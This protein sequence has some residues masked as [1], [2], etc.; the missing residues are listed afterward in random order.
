MASCSSQASHWSK[1]EQQRVWNSLQKK[2][3]NQN[4]S[5]TQQLAT[6]QSAKS[7]IKRNGLNA[8][9]SLNVPGFARG[10]DTLAA[11]LPRSRKACYTSSEHR[12]VE[13]LDTRIRKFRKG[14]IEFTR[15]GHRALR[16][17]HRKDETS[18][19]RWILSALLH[20]HLFFFLLAVLE[21]IL[22]YVQTLR[23][24]GNRRHHMQG[25]TIV[26]FR[27]QHM[28]HFHLG[29]TARTRFAVVVV[30]LSLVYPLV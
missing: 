30:C 10:S 14:Q 8:K 15:K 9:P 16:N 29:S 22:L 5:A 12:D 4:P 21:L 3:K 17:F 19:R 6:L 2:E 23:G 1:S 24:G 26:S 11:L 27:L 13:Q 25:D 18:S 20:G 28:H 7:T